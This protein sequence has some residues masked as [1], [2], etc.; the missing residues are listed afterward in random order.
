MGLRENSVYSLIVMIW[1]GCIKGMA[2]AAVIPSRF[3]DRL[4]AHARCRIVT[5]NVLSGLDNKLFDKVFVRQF[6]DWWAA[7]FEWRIKNEEL[8]QLSLAREEKELIG[9]L[10]LLIFEPKPK[11]PIKFRPEDSK[12]EFLLKCERVPRLKSVADGYAHVTDSWTF[13]TFIVHEDGRRKLAGT[14]PGVSLGEVTDDEQEALAGT[15]CP[16][17]K[18]MLRPGAMIGKPEGLLWITLWEEVQVGTKLHNPANHVRDL[19]GLVDHIEG[20]R[21]IALRIPATIIDPRQ[22]KCERS[23]RPTFADAG[24]RHPRF[25]CGADTIKCQQR[26]AWG[27]TANLAAFAQ[28]DPILDGVPERVRSS[29]TTDALGDVD[30][31]ALGTVD[32]TRGNTHTDD[33]NAYADRLCAARD[34]D[35]LKRELLQVLL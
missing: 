23:G 33:N 9:T 25:K 31:I 22:S 2:K 5:C 29:V 7:L 18:M 17:D 11:K 30:F 13:L 20:D 24:G 3:I 19:L 16:V 32:M 28:G 10:D 27:F 15:P 26:S 35:A 6:F 21:L 4:V 1:K 34:Q 8:A 12:P 14:A